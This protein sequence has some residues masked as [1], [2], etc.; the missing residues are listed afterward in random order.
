MQRLIRVWTGYTYQCKDTDSDTVDHPH[1]HQQQQNQYNRNILQE[2][3]DETR[4]DNQ[5]E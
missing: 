5:E 3:M 2:D 4:T 1:H